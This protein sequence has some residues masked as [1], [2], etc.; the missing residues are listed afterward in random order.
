MQDS[1]VDVAQCPLCAGDRFVYQFARAGTPIVRCEGCGLLFRNPQ[2]SDAELA[3]IYTGQYFL[4]SSSDPSAH[5]Q[6][7]NILKRQTAAR[8]L[9]EIE[10]RLSDYSGKRDGVRLLELGPGLGDFLLEA[11]SRGYDVTGVEYSD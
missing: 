3:G 11:A 5:D 2:P 9:D 7:T 8:Y 10:T 4:G 6:E 1:R